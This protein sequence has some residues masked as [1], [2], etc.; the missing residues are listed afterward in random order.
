MIRTYA[1]KTPDPSDVELQNARL[2]RKIAAE[3]IVLLENDGTLPLKGK[4]IALFGEGAVLPSKGEREA[5]KSTVGIPF[6][7]GKV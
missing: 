7:F 5:V 4:K 1:K 2:A 3:S 6:P